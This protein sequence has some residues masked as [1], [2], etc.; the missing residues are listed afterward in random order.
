MVG[1]RSE[2]G[3]PA[4]TLESGALGEV[5]AIFVP[6]AGM[7]CCSLRHRGQE[8]L[9]Q[10]G[11]L[12]KYVESGSTMGIPFLHP[13]ANR[14]GESRFELAG[15]E[16]KLG[17]DGLHIKRD[18]AGLP[19]HGLLTGARGWRV[20]RHLELDGEGKEDGGELLAS[21]DFGSYP[22]LLEAFPFPHRV[23]IEAI[24]SGSK[25]RIAT[26]V[27]AGGEGAVPIAFGF[28]PCLRL[29]GVERPEWEIEAPVR[30]RLEL[31]GRMLPTGRRE[32]VG[33]VSGLLRG[34]SFDDAFIA[35]PPGEPFVLTGGGRCLTLRMDESY[36]FA[37]IYAPA[38]LDAVAFE[39]MTA[40]TNALVSGEDLR[41]LPAGE[42]FTA[43]FEIAISETT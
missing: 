15:R 1:E 26:T 23:E 28:H 21:F 11:G 4:L 20:E 18:Q 27:R 37:Q 19:M 13:W 30:E 32:P 16:V 7:I 34:R 40:P 39:P 5:E 42:S 8:L 9:G 10:R 43:M 38:D 6:E 3:F 35:P 22:R 36:P 29:P 24:L 12:T 31:D 41:M 2:E 33:I 14:L 17:L 25:L